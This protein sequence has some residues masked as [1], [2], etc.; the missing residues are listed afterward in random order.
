[1]AETRKRNVTISLRTDIVR[2]AKILAAKRST[3]ISAMLAEQ[4]EILANEEDR[5]E[6]AAASAIARLER[7]LSLGGGHIVSRDELHGR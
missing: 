4:V 6:R 1:M 7:G 3:S 5:Y 2:K